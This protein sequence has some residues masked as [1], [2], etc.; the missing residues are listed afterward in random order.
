MPSIPLAPPFRG[1][2]DD[3][4]LASLQFP[5][6]ELVTNFNLDTGVPTLRLGDFVWSNNG[7]STVL[8]LNLATYG[9]GANSE[10]FLVY[11]D[12]PNGL[13][14]QDTSSPGAPTPV[15]APGGAGGDDEIHTLFFND[16]LMYFGEAS[17]IPA[18]IG[19][20]YYSGSAWGTV[21]YTWP[22]SMTKPFGGAVHKNR[23]YIIQND[24]TIYGYTNIDAVP[25]AASAVTAVDLG[26]VVTFGGFLYGIRSLGLSE[27]IEQENVIAFIFNTGEVLVYRGSYPDS[28]N[29]GLIGRFVIPELI[30]YNQII[31]AKGDSFVITQS[32]LVS[33]RTLFAQGNEDARL[34]ALSQPIANRWAQIF[35]ADFSG[36]EIYQRGIYDQANDRLI[37]IVPA[38]VDRD[39]VVDNT[40]SMRL[41]YSFKTQ[42]WT[43]AIVNSGYA[44]TPTYFQNSVF[45]GGLYKGVMKVEGASGY[46]DQQLSGGAAQS[47]S[48]QIRTAPFPA[49]RFGASAFGGV[50]VVMA[51]EQ[52]PETSWKFIADLGRKTTEA[53]VLPA[54]GTGVVKPMFNVGFSD[55]SYLQLDIAGL[56]SIS[57]ND[58]IEIYAF[59]VWFDSGAEGSR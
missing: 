31:D 24:S 33:L 32:A 36:L 30:Y 21:A 14:W 27:G 25:S 17:L 15:H 6:A 54:Q 43:E 37:I 5:F 19:P 48:Y 9:L 26:G 45:Y 13:K 12:T 49:P 7:A 28:P 52:Y 2:K 55:A 23:A 56:S 1:Q 40:R 38:Y 11:N 47:I 51:S 42:S 16:H 22:A 8:T 41:I 53:Q 59:N 46:G 10:M 50:E 44:T 39:G 57:V 4:P 3:I 20:Q 35:T 58:G 34:A 29:W 18:G